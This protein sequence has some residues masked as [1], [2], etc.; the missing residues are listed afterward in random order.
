MAASDLVGKARLQLGPWPAGTAVRGHCSHVLF[1]RDDSTGTQVLG[2][3]CKGR[4][5]QQQAA[6]QPCPAHHGDK[7]THTWRVVHPKQ[8]SSPGFNATAVGQK[9]SRDLPVVTQGVCGEETSPVFPS[10][11][12]ISLPITG[13]TALPPQ[14]AEMLGGGRCQVSL[15]GQGNAGGDERLPLLSHLS[16]RSVGSRGQGAAP[17]HPQDPAKPHPESQS[18]PAP[19]HYI[20]MNH[21]LTSAFRSVRF[22]ILWAVST[23]LLNPDVCKMQLQ[24]TETH[25]ERSWW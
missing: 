3:R 14:A 7:L 2:G 18:A 4:E 22:L 23:G 21:S 10:S 5:D 17:P 9:E 25:K 6:A 11:P 1:L 15:Q 12:L 8:G 20:G 13:C 16:S 19:A 24:H